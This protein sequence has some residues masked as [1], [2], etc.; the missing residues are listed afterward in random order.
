MFLQLH[1]LNITYAHNFYWGNIVTKQWLKQALLTCGLLLSGG[2]HADA[3]LVLDAS[4]SM[5]GQIGGNTKMSLA[6]A[7]VDNMLKTW[8][9]HQKLGLM[10]YGHRQKG[11]CKDI[12]V[13]R[14][15]S[16][17]SAA[18]IRQ[19]VNTL[20]PKGMTPI[21]DAV[22]QA[23]MQLRYTEQ[24]A[25]VILISDGEETCAADPCEAAKQLEKTGVDFTAHV[26]GFDLPAGKARSQLQCLAKNTGGQFLEAR[27]AAELNK[28]LGQLGQE[29]AKP[30]AVKAAGEWMPDS[31]LWVEADKQIGNKNMDD[32]SIGHVD[33]SVNDTAQQCQAMCYGKAQ[34]GAWTYEPTGSYFIDHPRCAM[35]S[36]N[37]AYSIEKQDKG[38]GWVSGVKPGVKLILDKAQSAHSGT[39]CSSVQM[40]S[41]NS[42][43]N[44]QPSA[45]QGNTPNVVN[46]QVRRQQENIGNRTQDE[47]NRRVDDAV[48]R[49]LDNI[50]GR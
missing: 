5:Q 30:C 49:V 15:V 38:A 11:D 37:F 9:P 18:A 22:T 21:S 36:K 13:L 32:A 45:L 41:S 47:I 4:G 33:M 7:A 35:K 16:E 46:E 3:M 10:A 2:V 42:Q 12:Q 40:H 20:H 39:Q 26:I 29:T 6:V 1:P 19:Q 31:N 44:P 34:C 28:A 14:P 24:K 43:K 17:F 27:N 8:S 23:A 48:G 50:F 25:T